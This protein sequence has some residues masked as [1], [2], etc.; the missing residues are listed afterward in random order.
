MLVPASTVQIPKGARIIDCTGK[1]IIPGLV[2]G[3]EGMNSQG[4]ASANLYMGVT[5]AVVSSDSHRGHID[6]AVNPAPH[7]YLLDSVGTTDD[8]SLLIGHSGWTSTLR[9]LGHPTELSPEET[10]QPAR[11]HRQTGHKG[12]ISRPLPDRGKHAVDHHAGPPDGT[13]HVRRVCRYSL[14]SR[15]RR[16]RGCAAAHGPLRAGADSQRTAATPGGRSRRPR[17]NNRIRLFRTPPD[18]P[19]S[20]WGNTR[21]SS[22]RITPR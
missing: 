5:T 6:L 3:F 1:Y 13:G 19:T 18:L 12:R 15:H 14:S 7:L 10:Q 4:E 17:G 11:R 8:W 21:G 9:V 16:R 22:L 2:D 20:T